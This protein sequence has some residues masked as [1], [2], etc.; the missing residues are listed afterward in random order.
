[1]QITPASASAGQLD[2]AQIAARLSPH[3]SFSHNKF[4][5]R[6]EFAHERDDQG[7]AIELT[8]FPNG[9]A[10]IKG[11]T[12]PDAARSIYAKYVGS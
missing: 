8:L 12:E 4:L 3:G 5:L 1:M 10:I 9:R 7:E 2:L 11:T 6:G